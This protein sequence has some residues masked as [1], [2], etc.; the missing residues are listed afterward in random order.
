MGA[1]PKPMDIADFHAWEERQELRHEFDGVQIF[2]MTGGTWAHTTI[3]SHL[4]YALLRRLDGKP[5]RPRG[6][7]MKIRTA[8]SIRYSDAFV[9]CTPVSAAATFVTEPVVIFEIL[10]KSTANTDIGAKKSEYQSIHSLQRYVILHQSHRAADVLY[11][12]A[13]APEGWAYEDLFEEQGTLEMPEIGI[14]IPL[15]EIYKDSIS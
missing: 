13:E 7:N 12:D 11:R 14:S 1:L 3:Q 10:S 9:I 6:S 4:M 2:A 8:T 15:G 5:C